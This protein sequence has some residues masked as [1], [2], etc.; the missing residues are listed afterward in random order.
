MATAGFATAQDFVP[1]RVIVKM[2][3]GA[4]AARAQLVLASVNARVESTIPQLGIQAMRIP[5]HIDPRAMARELNRLGV[6]LAEPDWVVHPAQVTPN[7]PLYPNQATYMNRVSAPD[8]WDLTTGNSSVVV[9]VLDTGVLTTHADLALNMVAGRNVYAD[10]ND[11]TDLF[12]HGT[13]VAGTIAAVGN[14]NSGIASMAWGCRVMPIRI[15]SATTSSTSTFYM[16]KGLTWAADNG[17]R[18]ANISYSGAGSGAVASGAAYF[19]SK[20][21]VM[22]MSAGNSAQNMAFAEPTD[23]LVVGATTWTDTLESYS[24]YGPAVSLTAP[25]TVYTT[26]NS[27]GYSGAAGTSFSSP[28]AAGVLAL[29]KSANPLLTPAR[30]YELIKAHCDDLG[31]PG[32]DDTFGNGRINAYEAVQAAISEGVD[33]QP[34]SVSITSPT[35]G[36][37]VSGTVNVVVDASDADSGMQSVSLSID[38]S[39]VGTLNAAPYQWS[40]NTSSLANGTHTLL[41][42]ARDVAGNT[43]THTLTV[44][45]SNADTTPPTVAFTNPL[46][47]QTVT[48]TV[49]VQVSA[50]DSG[51]GMQSVS[52]SIDGSSVGTLNAAPYQWSWNT[53]SLA[54]GTH[55]LLA[56]AR[57]VAGNTA[58]RS[59]TVTVQSQDTTPPIVTI[60]SP[61]G[62]YLA[63]LLDVR[64]NAWDNVAVQRAE[65]YLDGVLVGT[66][67]SSPF[68]I[69]YDTRRVKRGNHVV[70][71]RAWDA[72]GNS[73]WSQNVTVRKG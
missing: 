5:A 30:I 45:V 34:P 23:Y 32:R 61:T 62:G 27:G 67:T 69:T 48:G 10:S 71:V 17:A 11:V 64:V 25:G 68:T 53:S 35:N 46:Q 50:S 18:V 7:D 33:S 40:W 42:T 63:R 31:A 20:G 47:G 28:M 29:M 15:C 16:S 21:G 60:L 72:A 37:T 58:T 70:R 59:I 2:P 55:T 52:L 12:G 51:S 54:A 44:S 43:A 36:A 9:A 19:V 6:E 66:S 57:D 13:M 26:T 24:N 39:T 8:A 56:T 41:A 38:G 49:S 65:L 73:G 22:A 1:G 14:N 4:Q 3:F